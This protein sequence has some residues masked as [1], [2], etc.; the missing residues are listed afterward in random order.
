MEEDAALDLIPERFVNQTASGM[1]CSGDRCSALL[2]EVGQSTS[3]SIYDLRPDVC[4]ACQPGDEA[5][6]IARRHFR[7]DAAE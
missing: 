6:R 3:C 2:G 7:L 4:R 1:R 5:C